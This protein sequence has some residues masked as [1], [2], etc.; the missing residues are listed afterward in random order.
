MGFG[1]ASLGDA[2]STF[3]DC[4]VGILNVRNVPLNLSSLVLD[5]LVCFINSNNFFWTDF[6]CVLKDQIR[7]LTAF[8][9]MSTIRVRLPYFKLA[10]EEQFY[11]PKD[12]K[13]THSK[14]Q[15]TLDTTGPDLIP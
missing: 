12:I 10:K 5:D 1:S 13:L 8:P 6:I 4:V 11:I 7:N 15:D 14:S 2:C 3:R 9:I